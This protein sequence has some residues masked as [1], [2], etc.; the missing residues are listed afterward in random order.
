MKLALLPALVVLLLASTGCDGF[1]RGTEITRFPDWEFDKYERIAVMPFTAGKPEAAEAARQAGYELETALARNGQFTVLSRS[2]VQAILAEQDFSRLADV[3]DPSTV[4]PAGKIQSA[5]ALIVPHITAYETTRERHEKRIPRYARDNKGRIV[6]DRRT[7]QPVVVGEDIRE[8]FTHRATVSG[9]IRVLDTATGQYVFAYS[10]P[11]IAYEDSQ[12]GAPPRATPEE[13]AVNAAQ[14]LAHDLYSNVAP[15]RIKVKFKKDML[16]VATDWYDGRYEDTKEIPITLPSFLLAV[17]ELP[18]ECDRNPFRVVITPEEGREQLFEE[19]FV[20]S[21]AN[22]I[23]G[24]SFTIPVETLKRTGMVDF[25][26]KLYVEGNEEPLIE[27][28]FSL[29]VPKE[30]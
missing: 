5:Q 12:Q 18:D 26:A 7:G 15:I 4:I 10:S 6:R 14:E 11:P 22:P 16:L 9:S 3:S 19:E 28:T 30:E 27:R 24:I 8:I 25:V 29:E 20:W 2:E 13:L 17:T 21:K 23:R 1:G